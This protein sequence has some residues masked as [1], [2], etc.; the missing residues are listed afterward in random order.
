[1]FW[2]NGWGCSY[3]LMMWCQVCGGMVRMMTGLRFWALIPSDFPYPVACVSWGGFAF[4][5]VSSVTWIV[6]GSV[7]SSRGF[8]LQDFGL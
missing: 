3:I 7:S 6:R 8:I 5:A 2:D 4:R 1:M